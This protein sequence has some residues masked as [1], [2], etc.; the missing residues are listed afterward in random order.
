MR[1]IDGCV[2]GEVYRLLRTIKDSYNDTKDFMYALMEQQDAKIAGLNSD[3][4][5][6]SAIESSEIDYAKYIKELKS[7][8][9][10]VDPQSKQYLDIQKELNI[11]KPPGE[12][13]GHFAQL[14]HDRATDATN[15]FDKIEWGMKA[16]VGDSF[17]DMLCC[18][19][20]KIF[21]DANKAGEDNFSS[22]TEDFEEKVDEEFDK[23]E[24][25]IKKV[26]ALLL[27]SLEDSSKLTKFLDDKVNSILDQAKGSVMRTVIETLQQAKTYI[28]KPV[29]NWLDDLLDDEEGCEPF[30]Q[31]A[32]VL[33]DAIEE[34][35]IKYEQQIVDMLNI[36]KHEVSLFQK[37]CDSV[38]SSKWAR[39][40]YKVLDT[41]QGSIAS[42][43]AWSVKG[44][45]QEWIYEF[46]KTNGLNTYYDAE[47]KIIK[48]ITEFDCEG[49][50]GG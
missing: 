26:K 37:H 24:S 11:L 19:L 9:E 38:F 34:V 22:N 2:A 43:K 50:L 48:R 46:M 33:M 40:T 5:K 12:T 4:D 42:A 18:L 30:T 41:L 20:K 23:I 31:L 49:L 36:Q 13:I 44:Q 8:L 28:N 3:Q 14:A 17:G 35:E 1:G 29:L 25:M 27:F 39:D 45:L 32:D 10:V 6:I 47:E 16:T 7:K 21:G 15:I